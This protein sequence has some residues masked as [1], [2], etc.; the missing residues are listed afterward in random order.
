MAGGASWAVPLVVGLIAAAGAY[1]LEQIPQ[2]AA[3]HEPEPFP[4]EPEAPS[5]LRFGADG[6]V[7]ARLT[8]YAFKESG[9]LLASNAAANET[10]RFPLDG[11]YQTL[12]ELTLHLG[13]G[14]PPAGS[15]RLT[16]AFA[17][18]EQPIAENLTGRAVGDVVEVHLT[19]YPW[20][21]VF[22]PLRVVARVDALFPP[23]AAASSSLPVA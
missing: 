23:V 3:P 14:T 12:P 13:N 4:H 21:D 1:G 6:V 18:F 8:L 19:H 9:R 15:F 2:P 5:A 10:A 7:T 16:G 11:D 20:L 22:G 17:A